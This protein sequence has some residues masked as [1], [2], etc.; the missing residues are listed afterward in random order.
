MILG[1]GIDLIEI[2]RIQE[3]LR[4]FGERFVNRVFLPGEVEYCQSMKFPA[5]HFA[6]RFAAKEAVSK[7]FGT[8]IGHLVGWKDIE[9]QRQESGKPY[10]V[11]HGNA[12][13]L[14]ESRGI[15][16]NWLSLTHHQSSAAAVVI[17]VKE[18]KV[19]DI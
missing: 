7:A 19:K 18:L 5:R 10:L 3:S 14:A 16:G 1:V 17:L 9:V 15:N 6:V 2:V 8:G 12:A 11:L 4:R 13:A